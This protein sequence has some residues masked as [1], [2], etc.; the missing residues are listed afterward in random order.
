MR[1]GVAF[2]V[3]Q[4]GNKSTFCTA[5]GSLAQLNRAARSVTMAAGIKP[6]YYRVKMKGTSYEP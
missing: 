4:A 1:F 3:R 6:D 2:R 5:F